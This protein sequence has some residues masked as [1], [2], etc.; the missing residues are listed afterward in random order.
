MTTWLCF[1]VIPV[2]ESPC[3]G[4]VDDEGNVYNSAIQC[5]TCKNADSD[6]QCRE[7]GT[8]ESCTQEDVSIAIYRFKKSHSS[9]DQDGN[10]LYYENQVVI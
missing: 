7:T 3:N 8:F 4:Q 1:H 10:L 9:T 2:P 6:E 5:L